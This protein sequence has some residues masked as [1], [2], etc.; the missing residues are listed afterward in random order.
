M[1]MQPGQA[2]WSCDMDMLHRHAG[3]MWHKHEAEMQ[4]RLAAWTSSL[5]CIMNMQHGG[6]DMPRGQAAW[7]SSMYMQHG[8]AS[9]TC[10]MH[11]IQI[12][13]QMQK[14]L[15]LRAIYMTKLSYDTNYSTGVST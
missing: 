1:Y 15:S 11:I 4:H 14:F 3:D 6:M 2:A 5:I 9:W 13:I 12:K 8:H 7:T 10:S